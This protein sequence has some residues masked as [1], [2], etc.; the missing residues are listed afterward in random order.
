MRVH[1]IQLETSLS[2][3]PADRVARAAA[4]VREQSGADL[5][6]LP[7]LWV[8]GGFAFG[9]FAATAEAL[10]G[11]VVTALA[12]AARELGAWLHGG[13]IVERADDGRLFNTSVLIR[14]DGTLAATYRKI[15]LF[16][17]AGGETKVL[18]A[19]SDVVTADIDGITVAMA[20]CYDLRFPELF[21]AFVDAGAELFLLPAAWPTPRIGHWSLLARARAIEDQAFVIALNGCGDQGGVTLGGR[22]AVVDPWGAVLA[23]GGDDE[24]V[25]VVD[26]DLA[27]VPKVRADFPVLLDRRLGR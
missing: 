8:Q 10:D 14:P 2:E 19:G 17:F 12:D 16:G 13:S 5:V 21:R 7:E 26:I 6:V 24:Q 20:T 1:A 15:H 18:T 11:P 22:S 23:E 4:L 25:L 9:S 3:T 27:Q